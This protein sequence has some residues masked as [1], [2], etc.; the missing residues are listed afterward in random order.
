MKHLWERGRRRAGILASVLAVAGL[1]SAC[2]GGS[3]SPNADAVVDGKVD[4]SKV[5]LRVGD[6]KGTSAQAL[7]KAA[8]LDDTPYTI[9]WSEFTSG[10]P[11]LEALEAGSID[12]GMVGNTPPIF[13]AASGSSFKV[14]AAANYTGSGDTIIVPKGSPITSVSQ[15]KGKTVGV[16]NGSSANYNLL[17]QL[18]KAGLSLSDIKVANLQPADALAAFTNGRL[19]AWAIWEPYTSQAEVEDGARLLVDGNN[20]VM[21]GLTFQAASDD[22]IDDKA[23]KAALSD[24]LTRIQ[25]AQVWSGKPANRTAWSK[26]WSEGTGLPVKISEHATRIRPVKTVPIDSSVIASEQKM[27]DAFAEAKAIPEKVKLDDYFTD[28]FNDVATGSAVGK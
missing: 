15:L 6:Q 7:L 12:V 20:G 17:G 24:Y 2:G 21:N 9:K 26:V 18:Q 13:A 23:T 1:L 3:S 5:T 28:E 16:A 19:D 27:A 11:M 10:P 25:K 22:A 4:L 8:G 14:V